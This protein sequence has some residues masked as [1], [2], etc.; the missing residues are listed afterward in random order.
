MDD[1]RRESPALKRVA[2]GQ[3]FSSPLAG[4]TLALH[5]ITAKQFLVWHVALR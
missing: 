5:C 2:G 4:S 1:C 3:P